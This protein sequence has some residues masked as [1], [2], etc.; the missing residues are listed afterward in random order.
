M[1]VFPLHT[2]HK[3]NGLCDSHGILTD[4]FFIP[5]LKIEYPSAYGILLINLNEP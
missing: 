5:R 1:H 2:L 4:T 3:T